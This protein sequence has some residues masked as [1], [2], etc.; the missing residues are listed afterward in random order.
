MGA[1][2]AYETAAG[3][4]YR[5]RYRKPDR[6][7]TDKRGFRTK[8]EAELYLASVQVAMARGEFVNATAARETIGVLGASWLRFQT[9]L[10]PS[11]VRPVEIAW[12]LYVE[13]R[14]GTTPV[15]AV[16]YSDVQEWVSEISEGRSATTV[17]RA[18]GVLASI[19]DVAARDRR[20][21][22]NPARG[23]K[24]PRK[25]KKAHTYLTHEQGSTLALE[26]GNKRTF[27][28]VLA[29]CGLRW[30]E[31]V[32]LRVQDVDLGRRRLNV[33]VNAVEVADKIEIGTPKTHKRR[34]VP[35]PAL[36][37]PALVAQC[38][39]R[40]GQ[41]LVFEA[42]D[43]GYLRRT[44]TDESSRGW[45]SQAVRRAGIPRMTPHDLR[46]TAASLAIQSGANM[47]AV[48]RMLGHAS[49]AMTLDVY[50]DLFDDD[51]DLVANRLNEGL[52]RTD[53]GKMW[54]NGTS[55]KR[56]NPHD[57]RSYGDR[58]GS[59][60]AVAVGFEACAGPHRQGPKG[61]DPS[62]GG[63]PRSFG[64][65]ASHPRY[66]SNVAKTWPPRGQARRVTG[67]PRRSVRDLRGVLR[68]CSGGR[69]P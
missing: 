1:I 51:L 46:H 13:P 61:R 6:S 42:E 45:F 59:A 25:N 39:G 7:Q 57:P 28:L 43:G 52:G 48:Q 68:G 31:A 15:S 33:T 64:P 60:H 27:V 29:Y 53:V 32:G 49:A 17:L 63:L 12:R 67:R 10:K 8:R 2:S 11:S 37:G 23:V 9:H 16:R 36:L 5:V 55:D 26:C 62:T 18:H 19:L 65:L 47:K 56:V 34:S 66:R 44:R 50:A 40:T 3:R 30:G 4:R 69:R 21:S 20:I 38:A 54:A 58:G 35:F 24:M 41:Q 14:W 22:S